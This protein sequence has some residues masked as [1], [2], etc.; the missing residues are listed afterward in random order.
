MRKSEDLIINQI[1]HKKVEGYRYLYDSYYSSLSNFSS[2]ILSQERGAE[3]IVQEVFLKLWKSNSK[4]DSVKALSSYLYQAVKNASLNVV[5]NERK[6]VNSDGTES[7]HI[8]DLGMD[9]KSTEQL[10]IEEEFYRQIYV[11]INK[12]SPERKRVIL[13]SMDGLS[14]KEIAENCGISINTVKTL[15]LKAYRFLREEL[16]QPVILFFVRL[17]K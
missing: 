6:L 9:E 1:N 15:K 13:Y 10:I 17:M 4:F 7:S 8:R 16:E 3:D 12:L 5:R 2:R 11:A 14:N